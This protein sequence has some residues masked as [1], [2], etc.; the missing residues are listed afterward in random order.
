MLPL[1][2]HANFKIPGNTAIS[3]IK[4]INLSRTMVVSELKLISLYFALIIFSDLF[5]HIITFCM[6]FR[7]M[8][9]RQN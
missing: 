8:D 4:C 1:F 7:K 2:H 9:E 3:L 5:L 6:I